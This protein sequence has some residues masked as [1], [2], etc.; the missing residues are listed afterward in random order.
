[1]SSQKAHVAMHR[2]W[3]KL[4]SQTPSR[5]Q[6][7]VQRVVLQSNRFSTWVFKRIGDCPNKNTI[8]ILT[9]SLVIFSSLPS[10]QLKRLVLLT[11]IV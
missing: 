6:K 5:R 1:M 3:Q 2:S 11:G 4:I 10:G 8:M 7:H 9:A